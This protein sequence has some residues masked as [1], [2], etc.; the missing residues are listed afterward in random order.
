MKHFRLALVAALCSV[1]AAYPGDDRALPVDFI[2]LV[3]RSLSM[4]HAMGDVKDYL[5][6]DVIGPLVIPGDSVV[7]LA[8]FGEVERVWQ[9]KIRDESDKADLVRALHRLVPDG[10]FTDIGRALDYLKT[11]LA[12]LDAPDRWRYILLLT[13]ERQEAPPG[14][15]Y[16]SD[17]YTITH[18]FLEYVNRRDFGSFRAITIGYNLDERIAAA[19][20]SLAAFLRDPPN[21]T[22]RFL[23]GAP[24]SPEASAPGRQEA[25]EPRFRMRDLGLGPWIVLAILG[26]LV[27]TLAVLVL[28]LRHRSKEPAHRRKLEGDKV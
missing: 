26:A 28:R 25:A 5:A 16:A 21:R 18:R 17:D 24:A 14:S 13:D 4:R 20:G 23:P 19:A 1:S 8:F 27:V 3:D 11:V 9:G 10:R 22:D 15:P 2:F 12:E 7:L 6:G